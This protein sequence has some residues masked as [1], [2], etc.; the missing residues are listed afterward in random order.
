MPEVL[1][2]KWDE[3]RIKEHLQSLSNNR[4]LTLTAVEK[5]LKTC[6]E[7]SPDKRF[8]YLRYA[9]R[10]DLLGENFLKTSNDYSFS[11]EDI[12]FLIDIDVRSQRQALI[13]QGLLRDSQE[14]V[15]QEFPNLCQGFD[16]YLSNYPTQ[17]RSLAYV[18][19]FSALPTTNDR[20]AAIAQQ[21]ASQPKGK[22]ENSVD[23]GLWNQ[24]SAF[25]AF[26][27]FILFIVPPLFCLA[28]IAQI[29][30]GFLK[31]WRP[32]GHLIPVQRYFH[33]L[34]DNCSD[35][36]A[37]P[38]LNTWEAD[39]CAE[40]HSALIFLQA[41][42]Y[43]DYYCDKKQ[44]PSL[45]SLRLFSENSK[46]LDTNLQEETQHQSIIDALEQRDLSAKDFHNDVSSWKELF[47]NVQANRSSDASKKL[48]WA[49]FAHGHTSNVESDVN[50]YVGLKGFGMILFE[51][52]QKAF[53][54]A[55][56]ACKAFDEPDQPH[57][58]QPT[59]NDG[60]HY[61]NSTQGSR[62]APRR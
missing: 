44:E 23:H 32:E 8:E 36:Q 59:S 47:H 56:E 42:T 43:Y 13:G 19:A 16:R 57:G 29:V 45:E 40:N 3:T 12:L 54:L 41:K 15:N 25:K 31:K 28:L 14:Y 39:K 38:D 2:P 55:Y 9:H 48:L 20:E 6:H 11:F 58:Q 53:V 33:H 61:L 22:L 26:G 5:H 49:Y 7:D 62:Q 35:D 21:Q 27:F 4:L 18:Q 46:E 17:A 1:D 10:F 51:S 52:S 50:R 37:P 30:N 34:F 24:D 60:D